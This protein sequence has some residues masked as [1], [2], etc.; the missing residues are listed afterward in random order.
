MIGKCDVSGW[1]SHY[2]WCL[3][4]SAMLAHFFL[5]YLT[6]TPVADDEKPAPFLGL[7]T[8]DTHDQSHFPFTITLI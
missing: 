6:Q 1:Q 4:G 7:D 3:T 5:R 2:S 8:R